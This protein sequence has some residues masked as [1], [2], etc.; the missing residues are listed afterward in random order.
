V[1]CLVNPRGFEKAIVNAGGF[2]AHK[3]LTNELT[4]LHLSTGRWRKLTTIPHV[5]QCD[6]G[7]AVLN[8]ELYVVGG[9]FNQ[10]LQEHIHPFGFKYDPRT[11]KWT[12]I[13]P[14]SQERCRFYLG[15]ARGCLYAL[16][17]MGEQDGV[18]EVSCEK[19][20]PQTDYWWPI[21]ALPSTRMQHAGADY[22]DNIYISGGLDVIDH[23]YNDLLMFNA[24][25]DE[26]QTKANLLVP[27]ADHCMTAHQDRLFVAGGWYEDNNTGN[28]VIVDTVDCYNCLTNQW[29]QLTQL[30]TP[31]Y[32][33][34]TT[35]INNLLYVIGGFGAGQYNR[36]SRKI[37][38]YS[39]EK[40][41]WVDHEEYPVE[42]REH[43]SCRLYVPVC[44]RD[45]G[46]VMEFDQ[47]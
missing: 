45:K 8:N 9:C 40:E 20:D 33:M 28:R 32:H 23:T 26:W 44:R 4:Y 10:S 47:Y 2:Q 13:A 1:S 22:L 31:R 21:T 39:L 34:S 29:A 6:F 19:Y 30:P 7:I 42:V 3:G 37:E 16:G 36:A 11:D 15:A 43:V 35:V 38:T 5:E 25:Q 41:E 14:M 24:L 27:R 46:N 18:M 12:T 17:G